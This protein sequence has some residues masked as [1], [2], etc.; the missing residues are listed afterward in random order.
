MKKL[1]R[2][3]VRKNPIQIHSRDEGY[4]ESNIFKHIA[5]ELLIHRKLVSIIMISYIFISFFHIK[6]NI[7]CKEKLFPPPNKIQDGPRRELFLF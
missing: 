1:G 6:I 4:D 5:N 3:I 7:L 2:R